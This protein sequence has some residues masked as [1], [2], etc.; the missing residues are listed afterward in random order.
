MRMLES[1]HQDRSDHDRLVR[2]LVARMGIGREIFRKFA[3]HRRASLEHTRLELAGA[4]V[5]LHAAADHLPPARADPA[6]DAAVGN[7]LDIAV[8]EQKIDQHAVIVRG[9]PDP[10][11]RKDVERTLACRLIAE[12]RPAVERTLHDKTRLAGMG[13]RAGLDRP[14]DRS[15]HV[16]SKD[17]PRA[18]VMLDEMPCDATDAHVDYQLPEAPP[19]PKLPPPPPKLLSLEL[20]LPLLQPPPPPQPELEPLDQ[21]PP[22]RWLRW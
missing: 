2:Q 4:E 12:Q 19:P 17:A 5:V 20:E 10:Q 14:L 9:V 16:G 1:D 7:N 13:G 21:P 18:P 11:M 15:Q 8:G 22:P 3:R 6:V